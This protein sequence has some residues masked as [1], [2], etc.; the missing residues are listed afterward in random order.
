MVV[1]N[2]FGEKIFETADMSKR[3]D[4]TFNGRKQPVNAYVWIIS[5]TDID[6]RNKT[7]KG[8]VMLLK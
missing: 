4:G 2:R 7:L 8:T 6:S 5:L 1:Y 3:W